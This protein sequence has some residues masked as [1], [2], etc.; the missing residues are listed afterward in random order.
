MNHHTNGRGD[1]DRFVAVSVI[2][3]CRRVLEKFELPPE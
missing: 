3:S 1:A 2:E